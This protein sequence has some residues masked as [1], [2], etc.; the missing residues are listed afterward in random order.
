MDVATSLVLL[1][2]VITAS[3]AFVYMLRLHHQRSLRI[4]EMLH[5]ERM[6]AINQGLE[7]PPHGE[8][9]SAS[10]RSAT[11][12]AALGAGLV[13][14]LGGVGLN[15][16]FRFVP[17]LGDGATGLHTLSSLG[18]IPVFVGVGLLIFAWATRALSR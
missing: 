2:A 7:L 4:N 17:T 16:A 5:E 18:V 8:L 1:T 14:V 12:R 10:E 15:V 3:A 11:P 6:A 13:L 9:D